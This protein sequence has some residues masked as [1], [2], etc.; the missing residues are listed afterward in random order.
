M[1]KMRKCKICGE[2]YEPNGMRPVCQKFSCAVAY[3]DLAAEKS[4][5]KREK[6]ERA[7]DR[8]K[9][10]E[11][12]PMQYWLKRTEKAVNALA[13]YRD[14]YQPCISCGATD[15][16][17][18]HAG[19][20]KSVGANSALRYDLSN[21]HRQC[22]QCNVHKGGNAIEYELRLPARIGEAEVNRLKYSPRSKKWTREELQKIEAGAKKQ[23]KEM[24]N[25]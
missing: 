2:K 23:L 7:A 18:Y 14:R 17:A 21:I 25:E 8:A 15:A 24:Q 9:K 5:Q 16:S 10:L 3:A 13:L 12:K 1:A 22:E 11:L 4:K 20:W 6:A 19:H